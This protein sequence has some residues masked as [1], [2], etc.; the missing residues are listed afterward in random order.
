MS[1][2]TKTCIFLLFSL[3]AWVFY[4]TIRG[5]NMWLFIC[6]YWFV[7]MVKNSIDLMNARNQK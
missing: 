6:M 3:S 2:V 1:N 7:L 5:A 4:G